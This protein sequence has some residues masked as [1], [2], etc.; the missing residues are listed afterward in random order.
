[1]PTIRCN[2]YCRFKGIAFMDGSLFNFLSRLVL[3]RICKQIARKFHTLSLRPQTGTTAKST[4]SIHWALIIRK[5][6]CFTLHSALLSFLQTDGTALTEPIYLQ[7]LIFFSQAPV[8][9]MSPTRSV[10]V[11]RGKT[12]FSCPQP[13]ISACLPNPLQ[14]GYLPLRR[15][16]LNRI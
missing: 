6:L 4:A 15:I 1:M 12:T 3:N 10:E 2:F 7:H 5:T 14:E 13:W 16:V 8:D 9:S 11:A